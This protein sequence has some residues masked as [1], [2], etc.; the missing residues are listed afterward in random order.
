MV[1]SENCMYNQFKLGLTFL[2]QLTNLSYV[3][4]VSLIAI[5]NQNNKD[6]FLLPVI[7]ITRNVVSSGWGAICL[8]ENHRKKMFLHKALY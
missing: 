7:I 3:S 2:L 4:D 8:I 6:F 1:D 5:I